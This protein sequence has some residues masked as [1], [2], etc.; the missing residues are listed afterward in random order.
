MLLITFCF[1]CAQDIEIGC[2]WFSDIVTK[3]YFDIIYQKNV[4]LFEV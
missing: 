2:F 4:Y 3:F 1:L